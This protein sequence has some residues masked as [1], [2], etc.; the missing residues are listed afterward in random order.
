MLILGEY[1]PSS[2]S[3]PSSSKSVSNISVD[4]D[5]GRGASA[6]MSK[7][8]PCWPFW[9]ISPRVS[10]GGRAAVRCCES[11]DARRLLLA[12]WRVAMARGVFATKVVMREGD[13]A[14]MSC[15]SFQTSLTLG[16]YNRC[17][18]RC[19]NFVMVCI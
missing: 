14:T 17:F 16:I 10:S 19:R 12:C 6:F 5:I 15:F 2:I 18:A 7:K 1:S 3:L 13:S 8:D 11:W 9:N 4:D